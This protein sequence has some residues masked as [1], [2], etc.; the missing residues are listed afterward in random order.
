MNTPLSVVV[1]G[2]GTAG[3]IE[4]ALAVADALR[5]RHDAR[6]TALGTVRGL[7]RDLVP[8]RGYELA[9]IDPVPVPRKPGMD[10][11][12]L[13]LRVRRAV[14]Q[15]VDVLREVEADVLIG[16]GGYVA[17]PAYLAARRLGIPFFVHEANAR[18]GLANKLG[19]WCGGTGL[20]AVADSGLRGEV[21]GVPIRPGLSGEE[22][23]ESGR[24]ARKAQAVARYGLDPEK[25][26]LLVTGGSQGAASINAALAEAAPEITAA[27][28]QILHAHG[29]KNPAPET[30]GG[31][32]TLPYIDTMDL[33]L[34]VADLVVCR[35]GAMTV[36]E[37]TASGLPA[38]YVPL[39]HGNGEQELNAR[40]VIDAGGAELIRD[41]DLTG[42]ALAERVTAL[43]GDDDTLARL[44]A[45][46]RGSGLGHAAETIADLVADAARTN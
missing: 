34:A 23:S 4:P 43:L 37:V 26:T 31:W 1:A 12:R 27:G 44:S 33:A 14:G 7:E 15:T 42:A 35:A 45:A 36:A 5:S 46:T 29:R 28:H 41:A 18:A 19:V 38:I 6:V 24:A 8:A 9:L 2:G 13:P 32:H 20:N 22:L 25:R 3:H 16:F 10:L 39:P 11:L 17:A 21:V 40:P 30:C